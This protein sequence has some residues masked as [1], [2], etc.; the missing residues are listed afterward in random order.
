MTLNFR[1]TVK[2][3]LL[4]KSPGGTTQVGQ[5]AHSSR[6]LFFRGKF[7]CDVDKVIHL[8]IR[9]VDLQVDDFGPA[10]KSLHI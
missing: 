6:P 3:S 5:K 2:S 7:R 4:G 8:I 10:P 9:F 1:S